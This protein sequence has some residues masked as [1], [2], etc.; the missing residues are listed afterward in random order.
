MKELALAWLMYAQDYDETNPLTAA[1]RPVTGSQVYWMEMIDPY[2]KGGVR[3]GS[4]GGNT[5]VSDKLSI[6]ICP[7]YSVPAPAPSTQGV[8][9]YPLTSYAPNIYATT[10]WWSSPIAPKTLAALAEPAN[11]IMLAPN[12]NCCV[13]T[14]YDSGGE[15]NLSRAFS[16]HGGGANY[17]LYDGHVKWYKG[18]DPVYNK[19]FWTGPVCS[20]KTERPNCAIWFRP[21]G[22]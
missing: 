9:I 21:I 5:N 3:A 15:D 7:D 10:A 17:A 19:P 6:Y 12:H 22:G 11:L 4:G 13:E 16:R 8:G 20:N 18:S 14:G 2:V 1:Q